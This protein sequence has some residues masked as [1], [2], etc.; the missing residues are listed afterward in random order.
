ML[1]RLG[2]ISITG[3]IMSLRYVWL[4]GC[5]A[6][7]LGLTLA[8]QDEK[9]IT[10]LPRAHAHNDY[11]HKRP[12]LDALEQGFCSVEADVYLVGQEL[13]VGHTS[14]D[15]KPER[16]LEKLYLAPLKERMRANGG[17]V[18]R[19]GPTFY[20]MIDVK[21]DAKATY[22][23]VDKVLASYGD[24][25]SV[26]RDGK[27]QAGAVTVILSGNRDQETIKSQKVCYVGIDGRPADLDSE[28]PAHQIPWIST[29]WGSVFR[30]KGEGLMSSA[31]RNKLKDF[32]VKAHRHGRKVR[33]WA[34]P[35]R[36]E[37]WKELLAADVDFINTDRLVE[38]R[39][40]LLENTAVNP[41]P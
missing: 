9:P 16:T 32:V 3:E 28:A 2:G 30:W 36:P 18:Y 38:L 4:F 21:T 22:A 15:L 12:L 13:L 31:E 39:R 37:L 26:V 41:K 5:A 24:M 7:T 8:A 19:E 11:E 1:A 14:R 34:T 23:A 25:L 6:S 17:R 33:F 29:S 10:P 27:F 20:L 40:F 35:E